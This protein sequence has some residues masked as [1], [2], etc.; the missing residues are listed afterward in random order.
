MLF[1]NNLREYISFKCCW[2]CGR[3]KVYLTFVQP[4]NKTSIINFNVFSEKKSFF[5][6]HGIQL[7][8]TNDGYI[9]INQPLTI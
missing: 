5:K 8:G 7:C 2:F 4:H 3:S 1:V 6:L 9:P